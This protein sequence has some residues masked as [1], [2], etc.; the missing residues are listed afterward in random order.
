MIHHRF[1]PLLV[2]SVAAAC[3]G[4][5]APPDQTAA[6][7]TDAIAVI[8]VADVGLS[9]P[10]SVLH[11]TV[12]DVYLVSNISGAPV[13]KD[14]DGF[15]TRLS[16]EGQV[17]QLKW[18][19]G[20]AADVTLHAPKGLVIRGDTLYVADIDCVRR[21]VRTTG[22]PAG[23][24]CFPGAT[25]LN[26]VGMDGNG[27]LY[28]TDSGLNADFTSS[29]TDALWSFTPDGQTSKLQQGDS[30]GRPNGIA[31][32]DEGGFVVTFGTGEIYQFGPDNR[33]RTVLPGAP[34]RQL[35]G[36]VFTRDGGYLFSSWGDMA[37]HR[38][39]AQ[40]AT[41]RLLEDVESP[42][43]IGYDAKRNRVLVPLFIPSKVVIKQIPAGTPEGG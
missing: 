16:P 34:A 24:I 10:E 37:V 40:G 11:D 33:R 23:E 5:D 14:D 19:D 6:P 20:T 42:A 2:A 31:F 35:D 30:L 41:S 25:F 22:A 18:I 43:D 9:T 15:I 39:D 38:V 13:A 36:I 21:F 7:A 12:A 4:G 1:P 29:G 28:V 17:E 26:D 8:E 3:G 27:T 32:N